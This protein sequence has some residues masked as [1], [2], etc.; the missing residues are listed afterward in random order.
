MLS[1]SSDQ[2]LKFLKS[3]LKG[4]EV[5]GQS[6]CSRIRY[7]ILIDRA[8]NKKEVVNLFNFEELIRGIAQLEEINWSIKFFGNFLL[9]RV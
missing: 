1:N 9:L 4:F 7:A 3:C 6:E 2:F 5:P 8:F